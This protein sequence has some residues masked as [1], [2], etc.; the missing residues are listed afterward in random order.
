MVESPNK[1]FEPFTVHFAETFIVP[2]VLGD[3]TIR[4]QNG[5]SGEECATIKAF[6]RT[7]A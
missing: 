4:P 2:A 7:R 5:E 6:V 3:Y 1:R